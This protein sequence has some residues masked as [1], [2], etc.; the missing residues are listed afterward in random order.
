MAENY[1]VYEITH[2][3]PELKTVADFILEPGSPASQ[4]STDM[5]AFLDV[6]QKDGITTNRKAIEGNYRFGKEI[7]LKNKEASELLLKVGTKLAIP[8][9]KI[10]RVG[11]LTQGI[12]VVSNDI[13]A[14]KARALAELE[15]DPGY[16]PVSKL[17][18]GKPS[19]GVTVESYPDMTVWIWCRALSNTP[20]NEG[21]I[22]NITPFIQKINTN[23]A[24]DGGNFQLTLPPLVC[25]ISKE[26]KWTIK[27]KSLK[28]YENSSRKEEYVAEASLFKVGKDGEL[29]RNEFLFHNIISPNDM[30]WIRFETLELEKEQRMRDN[31]DFFVD[32]A[33]LAGRV[34]DMIGLVDSN[35]LTTDPTSNDASISIVGRDLSKLFI[36]D[37]TYFYALEMSQGQLNF[38]G[39]STQKNSLMQRVF[40][41]NALQYFGLY[42]NNSIERVLKFVIQQLSTIRVVPDNLFTS[43]GERRN[44]RFNEEVV[45]KNPQRTDLQE[46]EEK[47][48]K[49]IK[50]L[51]SK[52]QL[53]EIKPG[54][55]EIE[56]GKIWNSLYH[57]FIDI[58][59]ENIRKTEGAFTS[60]WKAFSYQLA[61][62][63]KETVLEDTFPE[64]FHSNLHL[65]LFYT[66]TQITKDD[67]KELFSNID[68]YLDLKSSQ[69]AIESKWSEDLA[70]GIWQI[71]KLVIDDGVTERRIVDSSMSSA[72]GSLLNFVRKICQEPFVE[73]YMDTYG[74]QYHLIVRKPPYDWKGLDSMLNG[75]YSVEKTD[76]KPRKITSTVID[77]EPEDVLKEELSY[78]DA[79]VISWYHLMP[80]ANFIG[81]STTYSLA[82]LPA[83][84]FEE[85]ADIWGS[86]P[87]QLVHNYMPRLP[88]NS[89]ETILDVTEKQ[90]FEDLKFM[91][92]SNAYMPFVR[93][94]TITVNG[95]RRLKY[96]NI[97]RYKSTGEIFFINHVQQQFSIGESSIDRTTTIQVIRGMKEVLIKGVAAVGKSSN[98]KGSTF[99]YFDII[100]TKIEPKIKDFSEE[101]SETTQTGTKKIST[102]KEASEIDLLFSSTQKFKGYKWVYGADGE[103]NK[104]DCSGFVSKVLQMAGKKI[105]DLT[106]E[107]I[108]KRSSD[109]RPVTSFDTATLKEG[110]V[111]GLDTRKNVGGSKYGID[112]IAIV[113][114]NTSTGKLEL[115]ESAS[116]VGVRS[117]PLEEVL[118]RYNKISTGGKYVG[119]FRTIKPTVVEEEV[120]V[121]ETTTRTIVKKDI[122]REE[123]FS[124]FKVFK[125]CFNFFLRR[126]MNDDSLISNQL[127]EVKVNSRSVSD[128]TEER[129]K[130]FEG[131]VKSK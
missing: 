35:T 124:N 27:K 25:E 105:G 62:G 16:R 9:N 20:G 81:S 40:S 1:Q 57:F 106:A 68:K 114:R 82:Y 17:Q 15:L 120:P 113:V 101:V 49:Q 11:L 24:K 73:F 118:P 110:D 97:I 2:S 127:G 89:Q 123:I 64:Y 54:L 126:K 86:K 23:V 100:N 91:I 42:Y 98:E 6:K 88:L 48:K 121:Y 85:Y 75:Q 21:E 50:T 93:K 45:K 13:P 125:S 52:V 130:E 19:D 4:Y 111:I 79:A 92:E 112:H 87:M 61:S 8:T 30:V 115:A 31:E 58:R 76:N 34:Y 12:Q 84:F 7:G 28:R 128:L 3:S 99:S 71:V 44:K 90:A 104:I 60:G 51:R 10:D 37:G 46:L 69:P 122:I 66:K 26:G 32:K 29:K 33:N 36:E 103:D 77:I 55:E 22:F 108:M 59:K 67:E 38:S 47:I 18:G 129:A 131:W 94:G 80:Q 96:G 119:N 65:T 107:E 56:I 78:D 14:F 39:G 83:I 116:G 41:E 5:E 53:T 63:S 102:V 72:N 117:K 74:D 109:F 70:R 95:D 43:Y